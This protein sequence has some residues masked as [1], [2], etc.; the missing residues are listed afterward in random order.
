MQNAADRPRYWIPF[1]AILLTVALVVAAM[2]DASGQRTPSGGSSSE[3]IAAESTH[4]AA[5]A[6]EVAILRVSEAIL[7]VGGAVA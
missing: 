5:L 4:V 2:I 3:P 7:R 1:L 6:T